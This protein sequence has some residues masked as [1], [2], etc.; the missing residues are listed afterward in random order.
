M[1]RLYFYV[2]GQTEQRY[3]QSTLRSHLAAFDVMVEGALLSATGK[4][5]GVVHRGGGRHYAPVKNDLQRFLRQQ[6]GP[7]VRVT[8]IFDL[9]ALF[10]DFPG[11]AEAAKTK[12]IP[13]ERVR[14]LEDA[15]RLDIGD[16]RLI[17]HIQLHEFET[18]L[19]CDLNALSYY[20]DDCGKKLEALRTSAG[21]HL[22]TPELIDDGQHS[23]PSKRIADQ[24]PDYPALKPDA[25]VGIAS[26]I[27]LA[28]IRSKC[29]HFNDWLTKLEQLGGRS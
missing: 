10:S 22:A 18:I 16:P 27:D 26:I 24:F 4:R 3:A 1:I 17:P 14:K 11:T 20:F 7:D 13:H 29:P 2:E 8:T 9:Y 6:Q 28:V 19:F 12:H 23:A 5:D 25:P 21:Q 15:L